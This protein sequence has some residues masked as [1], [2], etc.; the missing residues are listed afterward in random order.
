[1]K[2][3]LNQDITGYEKPLNYS[4]PFPLPNINETD[5]VKN[6]IALLFG[7]PIF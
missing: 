5:P 7:R 6:P 4:T 2:D 1:M 3:T